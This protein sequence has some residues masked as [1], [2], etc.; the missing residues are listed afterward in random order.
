[1]DSN[2]TPTNH[3]PH[4]TTPQLYWFLLQCLLAASGGTTYNTTPHTTHTHA[5]THTHTAERKLNKGL[6][7]QVAQLGVVAAC[8][9]L[10]VDCLYSSCVVQDTTEYCYTLGL[11]FSLVCS[12]SSI[13]AILFVH[14][15]P[16]KV[17]TVGA[18][19]NASFFS[20]NR[21][22]SGL[23]WTNVDGCCCV[24]DLLPLQS[25]FVGFLWVFLIFT[26]ENNCLLAQIG[27]AFSLHENL[28]T[29]HTSSYGIEHRSPLQ[30]GLA[31]HPTPPKPIVLCVRVC[32]VLCMA[33]CPC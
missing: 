1:M 16:F 22:C 9:L 21:W 7:G 19:G 14:L 4:H 25:C 13:P 33:V 20:P 15:T 8:N 5:H 11:F 23:C 27:V 6:D 26:L 10:P 24:A 12:R 32:T 18:E 29:S 28:L 2:L 31:Y 30:G 17:Q 3:T